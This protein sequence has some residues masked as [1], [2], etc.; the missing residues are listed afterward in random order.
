MKHSIGIIGANGRMGTLFQ[1]LFE[2]RGI[3]IFSYDIA[4]S[5]ESLKSFVSKP[6]ILLLSVPIPKVGQLIG[7]IE[8]YV[9]KNQ[10]V[11][12]ITSIKQQPCT[13]LKELEA[14]TLGLHPLFG[15]SIQD[16]TGY[17]IAVCTVRG[18]ALATHFLSFLEELGFRLIA[19]TPEKHDQIMSYIQCLPHFLSMSF[20]KFL[21]ES[22]FSEGEF[23]EYA[24]PFFKLFFYSMIRIF[25]QSGSMYTDIQTNNLY[26]EHTLSNFIKTIEKIKKQCIDSP[27]SYQSLFEELQLFLRDTTPMAKEFTDSFIQK[28]KN[29]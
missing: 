8:P 6:D 19:T 23:L 16:P 17:P 24:P 9:S 14:E 15:P 12:D 1:T 2:G 27:E 4:D 25:S 18:G 10:L 13:L 21:E 20:T 29:N 7:E 11:A 28:I 22:P 3:K 26:F 5:K